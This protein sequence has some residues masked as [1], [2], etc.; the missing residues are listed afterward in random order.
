MV[1]TWRR[2]HGS[3]RGDDTR[4]R[5]AGLVLASLIPVAAVA[6]LNLAVADVALPDIGKAFD[7]GLA[8]LP[9]GVRDGALG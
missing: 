4:P 9:G 8:I 3:T 2:G 1:R 7:A 6:N 5:K